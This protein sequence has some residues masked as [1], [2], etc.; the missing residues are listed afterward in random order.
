MGC[1]A[2]DAQELQD[3]LGQDLARPLAA[4]RPQPAAMP[5]AHQR[6]DRT[7]IREAEPG[8]SAQSLRIVLDPSEDEVAGAGKGRGLFEELGIMPLDR[9][10]MP[11]QI[12]DKRVRLREAEK[13]PDACDPGT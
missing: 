4:G 6:S 13:D 11:Q 1:R 7:R 5:A 12:G 8:K 3:K 10:E 2:K 9:G